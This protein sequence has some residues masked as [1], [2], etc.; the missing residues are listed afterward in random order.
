[1]SEYEALIAEVDGDG[2]YLDDE[3]LERFAALEVSPAQAVTFLLS[4]LPKVKQYISTMAL[5]YSTVDDD[6]YNR[7][8]QVEYI[9][10]GWSGSEDLIDLILQ[11]F[12]I[13]HFHSR[14]ERGGYFVFLVPEKQAEAY[15]NKQPKDS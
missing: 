9:T 12:W 5:R 2:G 3:W 15:K 7:C 8:T 10:G 14:W 1:M 6:V 13:A 11:K 4:D